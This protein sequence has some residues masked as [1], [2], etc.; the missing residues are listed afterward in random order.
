MLQ[1]SHSDSLQCILNGMLLV[2]WLS[3]DIWRCLGA[4]KGARIFWGRYLFLSVTIILINAIGLPFGLSNQ[5]NSNSYEEGGALIVKEPNSSFLPSIGLCNED[6][7]ERF[8][9]SSSDDK[10]DAP[11]IMAALR[12]YG[13]ACIPDSG[14]FLVSQVRLTSR[15]KLYGKGKITSKKNIDRVKYKS[16]IIADGASNLLIKG[17]KLKG[18]SGSPN[19]GILLNNVVDSK[20]SGVSISNFH[21]NNAI[22]RGISVQ[23]SRGIEIVNASFSD[24]YSKP[25]GIGGDSVGATRAV[26][27]NGSKSVK[28]FDSVFKEI[29]S[30]EDGDCI[31]LAGTED[32][33]VK[34]NAFV[35]CGKRAIKISDSRHDVSRRNIVENNT[36]ISIMNPKDNS[37]HRCANSAISVQTGVG[38]IVRENFIYLNNTV[39]GVDLMFPESKQHEILNN[40]IIINNLN[41]CRGF[42][43]RPAI[44]VDS[45]LA[46]I[47][48]N[49]IRLS[50]GG[51]GIYIGSKS[52]KASVS[53]NIIV[54]GNIEVHS[55]S[56]LRNNFVVST[57]RYGAI[58]LYS[59]GSEI[60]NNAVMSDV[61]LYLGLASRLKCSESYVDF[62][63]REN[64][65]SGSFSCKEEVKNDK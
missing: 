52:R 56:S 14:T 10:D 46:K 57:L 54:N 24:L 33:I 25:N 47:H 9:A 28:I 5:E 42:G 31:Q 7:I 59:G 13:S 37:L 22:V 62:I 51:F 23:D 1:R 18:G 63:F 35:N 4:V 20:I 49:N 40:T 41:D 6:N 11:A 55:D 29:Y 45:N 30:F 60:V 44:A 21:A 64:D 58:E 39:Y 2:Q 17:I 19:T 34:G 26:W 43:R 15:Q 61:K 32:A 27:I 48:G 65:Y 12:E 16:L 36:I 53:K 38:N 3:F 8:G 50:H